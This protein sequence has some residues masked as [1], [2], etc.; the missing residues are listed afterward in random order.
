VKD[1]WTVDQSYER[2]VENLTERIED[3]DKRLASRRQRLLAEFQAMEDVLGPALGAERL[4]FRAGDHFA[5][6]LGK[7]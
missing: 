2:Q 1:S 7:E 3:F 6:K 4:H 5:A